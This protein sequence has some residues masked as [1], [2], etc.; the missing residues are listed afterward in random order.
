M[1]LPDPIRVAILGLDTSHSVEFSRRMQAPDCP[2]AQRVPGLRATACLR[3]PSPFQAESGQDQRQAQL[4]AWGV[5]IATDLDDLLREA[6]AVMLE[7]ND[8][9]LHLPWFERVARCG[10][11]V[12]IDKPLADTA[13]AGAHIL[14]LAAEHGTVAASASPLR[15]DAA[16][17]AACATMP[18]PLCVSVYGPLGRAPAGSSIVWYGVH[19]VE[20]LHRAMGAGAIAVTT[21]RDGNGAT[22][23]VDYG[24]RRRGTV[25]L[26]EGAWIYGGCLRDSKT[27]Q[28]FAVNGDNLYQALLRE[29][30]RFFRGGKPPATLAD[31]YEVIAILDAADRS[32]TSARTE[33]V[34]R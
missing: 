4:Q 2:E 19:A 28:A 14:R 24:D 25:E 8:P 23:I 27:A 31:A 1:D 33:P 12:F 20:M 26:S 22:L 15:C 18:K 29:V 30:E 34:Y 13:V 5:R 9:T 17:A 11:P 7:I 6:D 21:R 32:L 3:F 10:K 16:L